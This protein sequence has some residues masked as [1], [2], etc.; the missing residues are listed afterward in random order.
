MAFGRARALGKDEHIESTVEG[1]ARVGKA[2]LEITPPGQRKHVEQGRD[3]EVVEGSGEKEPGAGARRLRVAEVAEVFEHLAGHG[4]RDASP[5][6]SG[7]RVFEKRSVEGRDMVG[8]DEHGFAGGDLARGWD[9]RRVGQ[10]PD[11]RTDYGFKEGG[12]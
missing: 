1:F 4:Y 3:E 12:S 6:E 7:E 11:Q 5:D 9:D 8:D 2:Q 10:K